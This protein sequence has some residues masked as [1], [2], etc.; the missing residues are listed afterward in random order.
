MTSK[1]FATYVLLSLAV[2]A[3]S[4]DALC[5]Q[6][7]PTA[8]IRGTVVENSPTSGPLRLVMI[9]LKHADTGAAQSL[10]TGSDGRFAFDGLLPGRYI[11]SAAKAA[12]LTTQFGATTADQ[13]GTPI[14]LREGEQRT[15][16]VL[17][18]TRGAVVSGRVTDE[19]GQAASRATV[20]LM[21]AR[22]IKGRKTWTPVPVPIA[23]DGGGSPRTDENGRYRF[24]GVPAGQYLV[25]VGLPPQPSTRNIHRMSEED[26]ARVRRLMAEPVTPRAA[27]SPPSLLS[28]AARS[29]ETIVSEVQFVP[30]YYP[31]TTLASAA[32]PVELSA[33]EELNGIDIQ[34]QSVRSAT[35]A[36]S[37][38]AATGT[39]STSVA[40]HLLSQEPGVDSSASSGLIQ[41]TASGSFR[42]SGVP[43]GRY[44]L[45]A[46]SMQAGTSTTIGW[47]EVELSINGTDVP[48]V[49]VQLKPT[50]SIE[51]TLRFEGSASPPT[52]V[53]IRLVRD[54]TLPGAWSS[55]YS[56]TSDGKTFR[57]TNLAPGNYRL[58]AGAGIR[59]PGSPHWTLLGSTVRERD[60]SDAA[61]HIQSGDSVRD[62]VMR[63]TSEG[64]VLKGNLRGID[65]GAATTY[66][67]VVFPADQAL[68][69]WQSRRIQCVRVDTEGAFTFSGL[70]AGDYAAAVVTRVEA[71]E[72]FDPTFLTKLA[73]ASIKVTVPASGTVVRDIQIAATR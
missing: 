31:G 46:R 13:P 57:F 4:A 14:V 50:A 16:L 48:N 27:G 73:P 18:L 36:G 9:S 35:I 29:M 61:V 11:L 52:S 70:P 43:P 64:A 15:N 41:S 20:S 19:T 54:E 67:V 12:Y 39:E 51:G 40:V 47:G 3:V 62:A 72:W 56:M 21:Q 24:Y 59:A 55:D 38:S 30:V 49:V 5:A 45:E 6:Q 22:V 7:P 10:V 26:V 65:G 33:A 34:V 63:F 42:M 2:P 60:S 32:T 44:V 17:R 37:V 1:R 58:L 68:W 23:T 53:D 8:L 25:R 28:L 71:D 69:A 66:L